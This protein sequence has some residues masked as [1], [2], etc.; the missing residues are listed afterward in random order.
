M[1]ELQDDIEAVVTH[2][3]EPQTFIQPAKD[4]SQLQGHSGQNMTTLRYL[5]MGIH[6][7]YMADRNT[8]LPNYIA[9]TM[10][11]KSS[12]HIPTWRVLL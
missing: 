5:C 4:C 11:I 3:L 7:E 2:E 8:S 12:L 1:Q 10:P 6:Y 9:A